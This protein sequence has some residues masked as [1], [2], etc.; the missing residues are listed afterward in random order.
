M[1]AERNWNRTAVAIGI[2]FAVVT[3]ACRS[4]PEPQPPAADVRAAESLAGVAPLEPEREEEVSA[5]AALPDPDVEVE[6]AQSNAT[7][8]PALPEGVEVGTSTSLDEPVRIETDGPI[9]HA[10]TKMTFPQQVAG[11]RRNSSKRYDAEGHDLGIGYTRVWKRTLALVTV[12]VYP[13][14]YSREDRSQQSAAAHHAQ[15]LAF[16]REKWGDVEQ[17]DQRELSG[18]F[19]GY[20]CTLVV[21]EHDHQGGARLFGRRAR[22]ISYVMAAKSWWIKVRV[23][24]PRDTIETTK[25]AIDQLLGE[26]GLPSTGPSKGSDDGD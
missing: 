23:T 7:E 14:T 20:P 3:G 19:A 2:A 18:E 5:R 1:Q 22:S 4:A 24:T 16:V 17:I 21:S 9:V 12:Y 10:G 15:V 26:L 6:P 8:S 13:R 11:F 25:P